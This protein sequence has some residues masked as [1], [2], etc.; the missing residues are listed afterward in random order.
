MKRDFLLHRISPEEYR[1][2]SEN[3]GFSSPDQHLRTM[4]FRICDDVVYPD[5]K[6]LIEG[7]EDSSQRLTNLLPLGSGTHL[8]ESRRR[9]RYDRRNYFKELQE[10]ESGYTYIRAEFNTGSVNENSRK[11]H[12]TFFRQTEGTW[13]LGL[14]N[15]SRNNFE[16]YNLSSDDA[17]HDLSRIDRLLAVKI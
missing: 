4:T 9:L 16:L 10:H 11:D 17:Q 12:F 13:F 8:G 2:A 6:T 5:F 3:L 1:N 15:I 14:I 7:L